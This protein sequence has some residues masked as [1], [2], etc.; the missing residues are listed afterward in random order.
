MH[1]IVTALWLCS[2]LTVDVTP[3]F[4]VSYFF[5]SHVACLPSF[6][7]TC[8]T[9]VWLWHLR[10]LNRGRFQH[11]FYFQLNFD[12]ASSSPQS[13]STS[14]KA[15]VVFVFW[16]EG[17]W[18]VLVEVSVFLV[19]AHDGVPG[20]INKFSMYPFSSLLGPSF[21]WRCQGKGSS[22]HKILWTTAVNKM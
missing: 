22:G 3:E 16:C 11:S 15:L 19:A 20:R 5:S 10:V 13:S 1:L 17:D 4:A 9:S 8:P 12:R 21:Q 14:F 2:I 18:A 7:S 6:G